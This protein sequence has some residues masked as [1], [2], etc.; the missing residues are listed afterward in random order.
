VLIEIKKENQR[1]ILDF[2]IFFPNIPKMA[3]QSI[4]KSGKKSHAWTIFY[5]TNT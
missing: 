4:E 3:H 2:G 5:S 1:F